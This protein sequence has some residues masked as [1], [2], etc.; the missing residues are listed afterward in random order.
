[1]L[2]NTFEILACLF[3]KYSK[4]SSLL[5]CTSIALKSIAIACNY[6]SST[7]IW[8]IE[9]STTVK[10]WN[11]WWT[12][13]VQTIP[14]VCCISDPAIVF[15]IPYTSNY[16]ILQLDDCAFSSNNNFHT[17][18]Q[19]DRLIDTARCIHVSEFNKGIKLYSQYLYNWQSSSL[20]IEIK[21][22]CSFK[23]F[24]N[25]KMGMNLALICSV[26]IYKW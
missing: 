9:H 1:M 16:K 4:S 14:L 10:W 2:S 17:E 19:R 12:H 5:N 26:Y 21:F 13:K 15:P 7:S 22:P 6:F 24:S 3:L 18:F 25:P 20:I 11:A 23:A 8:K